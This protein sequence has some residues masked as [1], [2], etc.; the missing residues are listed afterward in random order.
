MN[1]KE[2]VHTI[3]TTRFTTQP[4]MNPDQNSMLNRDPSDKTKPDQNFTLYRQQQT[5]V[6]G[7]SPPTTSQQPSPTSTSRSSSLQSLLLPNTQN[8]AAS[9]GGRQITPLL[10]SHDNVMAGASGAANAA[11]SASSST[12][13]QD[14]DDDDDDEE[15]EESEM[16]WVQWY[17][18]RIPNN[19][20]L[21]EVDEDFME[22]D[23]NLC[24][25]P[26][27]VGT[28]YYS[29]ALDIMLDIGDGIELIL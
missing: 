8:H 25:L 14:D 5:Q 2:A 18:Q 20:F 22:D 1:P 16:S 3:F 13:T 12:E 23:F 19:E 27:M 24:G 15:E 7:E 26:Q 21:C 28:Q 6:S 29:E 10:G 11:S 4:R 17:T 9:L